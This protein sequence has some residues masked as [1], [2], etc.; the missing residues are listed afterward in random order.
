MQLRAV[1][2][3]L[4][5]GLPAALGCGT[6]ASE[7]PVVDPTV[8]DG[9]C[10]VDEADFSFFVTS[11]AALWALSGDDIDDMSGGFGGNFGG[12]EG[13][14]AICSAIG[15]ATGHGDRDW[16]AFLSATDDGSGGAVHAIDRI[17]DGPWTDANGRLVA[18][19]V[20]GLLRDARPD[21]DAQTVEDLPDECGVPISALGDAHDVITASDEDGRLASTDPQYTCNDWTADSGGVGLR[22]G[23]GGS[24]EGVLCG[25]SFP[26]QGGGPG[27]GG[28]SGEEWL[29]DHAVPGCDKGANL[30]QNGGGEGTSCIGCAGGYGAI[31]CFA[32]D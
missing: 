28:A 18:G 16:R 19:G 13:A 11:M 30:V 15:A 4:S 21:G 25:H 17:G 12:I 10:A 5:F 24:S 29:S 31:Y 9:W 2:T 3:L 32:A 22:A 14:D 23:G 7:P 8:L 6:T 27:G 1:L 20:D 26:R